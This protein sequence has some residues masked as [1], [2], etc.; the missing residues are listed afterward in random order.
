MSHMNTQFIPSP[1]SS[2]SSSNNNSNMF[3]V[4][5]I[6]QGGRDNSDFVPCPES[7]QELTNGQL[8]KQVFH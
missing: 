8:N 6:L 2:S 3:N 5:N 7:Y 4:F 1:N